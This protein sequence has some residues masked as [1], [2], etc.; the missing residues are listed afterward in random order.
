MGKDAGKA[1][2]PTSRGALPAIQGGRTN[3]P[4]TSARPFLRS[5]GS[6]AAPRPDVAL[7][8]GQRSSSAGSLNERPSSSG[9]ESSQ[10]LSTA[11]P[12]SPVNV[13]ARTQSRRESEPDL[14]HLPPPQRLLETFQ[15]SWDDFELFAE[16]AEGAR[17]DDN[18]YSVRTMGDRTGTIDFNELLELLRSLQLLSDRGDLFDPRYKFS[19]THVHAVFEAVNDASFTAFFAT[20]GEGGDG[21]RNELVFDEYSGIHH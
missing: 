4:A 12:S 8:V 9:S 20:G 7:P 18:V 10:D 13:P 19:V 1:D 21:Q 15:N 3:S 14:T 2:S 11:S 17:G 16:Y 5:G 6:K